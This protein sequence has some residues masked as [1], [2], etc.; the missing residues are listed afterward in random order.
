M[1]LGWDPE[2]ELWQDMEHHEDPEFDPSFPTPV[3]NRIFAHIAFR[4]T[5]PLLGTTKLEEAYLRSE[6]VH[7]PIGKLLLH[8]HPIAFRS[9][10]TFPAVNKMVLRYPGGSFSDTSGYISFPTPVLVMGVVNFIFAE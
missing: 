2:S 6:D 8:N 7:V 1:K 9:L 5:D 3:P 4:K 10:A